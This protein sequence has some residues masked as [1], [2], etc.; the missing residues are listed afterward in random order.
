LLR[1]EI[2]I[3]WLL[4]TRTFQ[5]TDATERECCNLADL[6]NFKLSALSPLANLWWS[7]KTE[8]L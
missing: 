5:C 7:G 6:S 2:L 3:A 1:W 4:F 8:R